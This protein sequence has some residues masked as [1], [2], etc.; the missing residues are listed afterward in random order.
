MIAV[1]GHG[2]CSQLPCIT[3]YAVMRWYKSSMPR[4]S[5]MQAQIVAEFV[6]EGLDAALLSLSRRREIIKA[7]YKV[8]TNQ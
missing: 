5:V 1:D 3:H 8:V 2:T 6:Y 4:S 7:D